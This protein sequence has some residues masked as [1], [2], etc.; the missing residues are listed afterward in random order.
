MN[1]KRIENEIR[2]LSAGLPL[3]LAIQLTLLVMTYLDQGVYLRAYR[4]DGLLNITAWA[5]GWLALA[6]FGL[7]AGG[8]LL[9]LKSLRATLP[10]DERVKLSAGYL[11]GFIAGLLTLGVRFMPALPQGYF[12]TVLLLLLVFSFVYFGWR[13]LKGRGSGE[14]IFP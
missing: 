8:A 6:L 3:Y 4:A 11:L 9:A 2:R 1:E 7:G 10:A 12:L 14:E 5:A 13:R